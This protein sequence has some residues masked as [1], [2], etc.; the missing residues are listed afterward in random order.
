LIVTAIVEPELLELLLAPELLEPLPLSEL[1]GLCATELTVLTLPSTV[2]PPG[3]STVTR[4]PTFASDCLLGSRSTVTICRVEVV[5]RIAVADPPP[6]STDGL[7]LF[8][9]GLAAFED[10]LPRFEDRGRPRFE[11]G[12]PPWAGV[13]PGGPF[14]AFNSAISACSSAI[15]ASSDFILFLPA[16]L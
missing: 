13:P 6:L 3:I 2:L 5:S 9:D 14:A 10:G 1:L 4:A 7:A 11:D 16:G 12:L 15:S 8:D